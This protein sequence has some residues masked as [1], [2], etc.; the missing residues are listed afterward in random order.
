MPRARGS[1]RVSAKDET[2]SANGE[3]IDGGENG[4]AI[5][6]IAGGLFSRQNSLIVRVNYDEAKHKV[7]AANVAEATVRFFREG[8]ENGQHRRSSRSS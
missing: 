3:P 8:I 1:L 2:T 4:Y 6:F 5:G 7:V